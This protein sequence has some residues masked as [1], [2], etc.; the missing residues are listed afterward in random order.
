[1]SCILSIANPMKGHIDLE[2]SET[3]LEQQDVEAEDRRRRMR[4][5]RRQLTLDDITSELEDQFQPELDSDDE[6]L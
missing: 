1:M 3:L 2:T 6:L 5:R 4:S